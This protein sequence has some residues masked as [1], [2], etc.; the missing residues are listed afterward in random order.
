MPKSEHGKFYSGDSYIVLQVHIN[1]KSFSSISYI[2]WEKKSRILF[3]SYR[4]QLL[5]EEVLI[6]MIYISGL[7]RILVRYESFSSLSSRSIILFPFYSFSTSLDTML[8]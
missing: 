5:A 3:L 6:G 1:L 2:S 8:G 7:E 4:R